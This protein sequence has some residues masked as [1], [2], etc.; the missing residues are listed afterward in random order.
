LALVIISVPAADPLQL[1]NVT[2]LKKI[3]SI[4]M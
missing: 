4:E 1:A 3:V 2:Q